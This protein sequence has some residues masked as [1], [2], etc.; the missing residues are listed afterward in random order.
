MS[1]SDLCQ[2]FTNSLALKGDTLG[3]LGPTEVRVREGRRE[4]W[5]GALNGLTIPFFAIPF[6]YREISVREGLLVKALEEK[7]RQAPT[8]PK[9]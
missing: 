1:E 6:L 4:N 2:T 3:Y 5:E 8:N 7:H 9:P